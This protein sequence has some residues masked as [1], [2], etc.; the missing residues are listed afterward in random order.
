MSVNC[1]GT[2][3][4]S[5]FHFPLV[6][7]TGRSFP[8]TYNVPISRLITGGRAKND[9]GSSATKFQVDVKTGAH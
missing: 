4:K 7:P 8:D 1:F 3:M 9:A 2:M 5:F 6:Q